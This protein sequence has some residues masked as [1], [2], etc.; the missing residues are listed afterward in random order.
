MQPEATRAFGFNVIGYASGNLGLGVAARSL[1]DLII[2][3]RFPISIYDL[4]PGVGRGGHEQRFQKFSVEAIE[5][6]PFAVNLF[7]LPPPTLA[8]LVPKYDKIFFGGDY[9][10]VA[11]SF[12]ELPVLPP[13]CIPTLDAMDVVV[14]LSESIRCAFQ[15]TLSGPLIIGGLL[16]LQ[17]PRGIKRDRVRFGLSE[18]AVIFAMSFETNSDPQRKN[19][20]AVVD[21]FLRGVGDDPRAH[22]VIK[23]N[24]PKT[25]AGEHSVL[26]EIRM[27]C[28]GHP[29]IHILTETLS[30]VDV[31]SLYASCDVYVSM[32]RA[33]GLG[34]GPM[35]AMALGK[36]VIATAWSGNMTFMNHTN[37]CLVS[38]RLVPVVGSIAEYSKARL[39]DGAYW[40]EPSVGDAAAWMRRLMGD[41]VLRAKLG[42]QAGEDMARFEA[43]ARD[44]RLLKELQ[45]IWD[46]RSFLPARV[47]QSA[48]PRHPQEL[49]AERDRRIRQLESELGSI[50][51]KLSYR[52]ARAAKR[53]LTMS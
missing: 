2:E 15:F 24:N 41:S 21:A 19:P 20:L 29:R 30:Y 40:A 53:F 36:P 3:K 13:K 44:G 34:L 26:R 50:T 45:A 33:E 9:I 43:E 11:V 32:H 28:A 16:P 48:K 1:I 51:S 27:R 14:A 23:V 4:D 5:D 10:N 8:Q 49:V 38:Y 42:A 7:V 12:W 31:L 37:A 39:G 6:L 25:Q 18:D 52:I 46:N 35:E 22:L 17:L 47:E